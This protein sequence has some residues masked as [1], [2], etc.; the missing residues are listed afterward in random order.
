MTSQTSV[1]SFRLS[2]ILCF[3]FSSTAI[4]SCIDCLPVRQKEIIEKAFHVIHHFSKTYHEDVLG[5]RCDPASA[6]FNRNGFS[7]GSGWASGIA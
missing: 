1:R 7:C 4:K 2:V 6:V 5:R 3:S